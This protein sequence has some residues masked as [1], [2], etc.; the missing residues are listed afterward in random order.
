[1]IIPKAENTGNFNLLPK[2]LARELLV[3]G[4]GKVRAVSVVNTE[5]HEEEEIRAKSFAVCCGSVESARLLLN[6]R[7]RQHPNGLA[8]SSDLV[9]RYLTGHVNSET[10]GYLD[11]LV[12]TRPINT[13]GATD[14]S[15]IPRFNLDGRK[16]DYVGGYQDQMQ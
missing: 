14:H 7:S 3:D 4:E 1:S 6:S 2:R 10:L 11:E 12:G 16:R 8:N 15:C 5:S 9:G 13:D